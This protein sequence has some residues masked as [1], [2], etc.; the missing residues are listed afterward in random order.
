M[1][2]FKH[3]DVECEAKIIYSNRDTYEGEIR[4]GKMHGIGK[5]T[6]A[7]GIIY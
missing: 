3:N 4:K 5:Y 1:G 7:N 2:K 6:Y